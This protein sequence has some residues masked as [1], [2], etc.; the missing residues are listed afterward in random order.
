MSQPVLLDYFQ[1]LPQQREGESP[2]SFGRRW[3]A[4]LEK[5]SR[6]VGGRY[7]EATL[8]RLLRSSAVDV[9][10]AAALAL[11]MCG[12]MAINKPL[13]RLLHDEDT[14]V[15]HLA[16]EALWSLWFRAGAAEAKACGFLAAENVRAA[17]TASSADER[18]QIELHR[19]DRARQVGH[20]QD[21]G[22]VVTTHV[23]EYFS[24]RR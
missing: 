4:G 6:H 8:E 14:G 5:F 20:A 3:R 9:R 24:I 13:A 10:R 17:R 11:G 16:G 22:I 12:T 23:G 18:S 15:R 7:N 1:E 19:L 21:R 2:R